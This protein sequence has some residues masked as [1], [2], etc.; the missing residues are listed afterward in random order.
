GR[1]YRLVP[2]AQMEDVLQCLER[3]DYD[4]AIGAITITPARLARVDFSYPTHRSGVAVAVRQDTGPMAAFM[5]YGAVI[6]ELAPLIALTF[7][8]LIVMGVAMWIAERPMRPRGH[9]SAVDTLRDGVYWAVVTMTTV[10]YGDK[11]PKTT[12]G[13]VIAVVWMLASV[14]LISIL[15]T[16]IVSR[17]TAERVVGGLRV[18]EANL[19]GK[20]LAAVAH[21]SGAEYLDERHL[22]YAPFDELSAALAA[23]SH[24]EADAVVNSVGALQYLISTRFKGAIRPPQGVLEPAYMAIALPPGSPLKKK[25]DEA[26]VGIT[27]SQE[28]RQVEDGYFGGQQ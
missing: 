21:S 14:A 28:W 3:K 19:A 25:L 12:A 18:T 7:A 9:E 20:R 16:S 15:S 8:L 13:R 4:A 22:R 11:T 1:E 6:A 10:G 26:L 24:G 27:A 17:M 2:V 5:S 23:L